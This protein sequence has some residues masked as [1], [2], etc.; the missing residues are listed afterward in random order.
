[1]HCTNY[2]VPGTVTSD[3]DSIYGAPIHC[4]ELSFTSTTLTLTGM[5]KL[6]KRKKKSQ[7]QNTLIDI[8]EKSTV[9]SC[10][11]IKVR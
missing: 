8:A 1:M 4:G 7:I 3:I 2:L 10:V 9:F 11:D 5:T 6:Y